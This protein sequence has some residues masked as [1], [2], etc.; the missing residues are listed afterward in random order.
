MNALERLDSMF[1]KGFITAEEWEQRREY[2]EERL[3]KMYLNGE[4]TLDEL[5][6]RIDK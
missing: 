6:E 3:L 2:Y 4:I 5:L 1:E